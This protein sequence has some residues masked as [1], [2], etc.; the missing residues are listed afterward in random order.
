VEAVAENVELVTLVG[1]RTISDNRWLSSK[2]SIA[3]RG[4]TQKH[5]EFAAPSLLQIAKC[6]SS[7]VLSIAKILP[8][9]CG[10]KRAKFTLIFEV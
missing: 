10:E 4:S 1:W 6:Y 3:M 9:T 8:A 7:C 2:K 5:F